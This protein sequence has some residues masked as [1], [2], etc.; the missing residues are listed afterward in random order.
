MVEPVIEHTLDV[1]LVDDG[2]KELANKRGMRWRKR[3]LCHLG[4]FF[5]DYYESTFIHTVLFFT[6]VPHL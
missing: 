5:G 2:G 4:H 6:L 3:N 1:T